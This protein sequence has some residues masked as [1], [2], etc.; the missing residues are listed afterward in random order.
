MYRINNITCGEIQHCFYSPIA[1]AKTIINTCRRSRAERSAEPNV[2]EIQ[3]WH[4]LY[5]L[6]HYSMARQT[7]AAAYRLSAFLLL[8]LLLIALLPMGRGLPFS[9]LWPK[10]GDHISP[11]QAKRP[12]GAFSVDL[13]RAS[14][15]LRVVDLFGSPSLNQV[16]RV[17]IW[18]N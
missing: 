3:R 15:N 11:C 9:C 7:P 18:E 2:F 1:C 13:I 16:S 17:S 6:H 4:N 12:L 5:T 14:S 8:I 10:W